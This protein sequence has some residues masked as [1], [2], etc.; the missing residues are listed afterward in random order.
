MPNRISELTAAQ[1]S[2]FDEWA[3]K[4][5]EIGLR[6]GPADRERFE[7]AAAKCYRYAG[8]PWH[9]NVV[10]VPSPLV[11]ALAAPIAALLVR[12]SPVDG[13]V[14]GAVGDAVS[15]AVSDA[16]GGA[17]DDA[18]GGAVRG[19]VDGA[20]DDAV[21]G[22]VSDAVD[23]AV[24]GA[25]RQGWSRYLGGQFWPGGWYWGPAFT[26]FFREVCGLSLKGDIWDR[27]R[28]YE[29]T[30]QSACW[31]WPHREFLIV[32]ERPKR[33]EREL[34]NPDTSKYT[35]RLHSLTGPAVEFEGWSVYAIHGVRVPEDVVMSPQSITAKRI[36]EERNAEVRRVMLERRGHD[37]VIRELGLSP[38][39][40]SSAGS[41]YRLDLPGDEP[42]A[43]VE[44]E[45][46]TLESDGSRK[47]YWLR[48]PPDM[49][50]ATA[51]V[52][53]TFGLDP[54]QYQPVVET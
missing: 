1:K 5:I 51:A 10:W 6:T 41:L 50:D 7:A 30:V 22:A 11:G 27:G 43:V 3:E 34:V 19:A 17:V 44:V 40:R 48:V 45:N 35:A 42:L 47:R 18:V 23:G 33:I 14:D 24:R 53:W 52:A 26:S 8:I 12:S 15:G 28:A 54:K 25:V 36:I 20:V 49:S 31:W 4:W 37:G 39:S 16:V 46:S 21:R 13:A 32:S 38:I 29:A 2:R 9:G